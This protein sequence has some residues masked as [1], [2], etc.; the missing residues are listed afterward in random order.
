[1]PRQ[2]RIGAPGALHHIVCRGIERKPIF[3]TDADRDDFVTRL[4]TIL[5]ATET[6]CYAWALTSPII[7]TYF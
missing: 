3:S 7:F 1:M 5:A 4:E 6:R 2:A